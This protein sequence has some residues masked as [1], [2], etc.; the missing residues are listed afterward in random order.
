LN[1]KSAGPEEA[2]LSTGTT[3]DIEILRKDRP[4][5]VVASEKEKYLSDA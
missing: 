2:K 1:A 5:G 4:E 3:F